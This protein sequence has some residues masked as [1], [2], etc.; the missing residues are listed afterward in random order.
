M[1]KIKK[2]YQGVEGWDK[3]DHSEEQ[4]YFIGTSSLC[5]KW[6]LFS[7]TLKKEPMIGFP[8]CKECADK[9]EHN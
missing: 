6:A 2:I 7:S 1:S 4:H 3:P 9:N 8:I 5:K